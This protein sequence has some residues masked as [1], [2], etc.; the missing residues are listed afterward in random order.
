MG[1]SIL[2][3]YD[4]LKLNVSQYESELEDLSKEVETIKYLLETAKSELEGFELANRDVLE[5]VG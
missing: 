5:R 3:E 1:E 4:G 2:Y